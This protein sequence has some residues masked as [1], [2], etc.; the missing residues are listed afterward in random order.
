V[1]ELPAPCTSS[2]AAQFDFWLGEWDLSWP[3]EQT[4]GQVGE[5]GHGTNRIERLLGQCVIEENFAM[6]DGSFLGRSLSVFDTRAELWMQTWVDSSGGYLLFSGGFDGS[7][8]ELRTTPVEREGEVAVNRMVFHDISAES[9]QWD[10]QGSRDG[11][12]TWNYL[13]TISYRRRK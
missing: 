6:D 5:T 11:G 10:W 2:E 1:A 4:G 3:A 9:L 13:W 12:Q 7:Q 8:M